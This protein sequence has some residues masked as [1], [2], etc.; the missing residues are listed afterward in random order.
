MDIPAWAFTAAMGLLGQGGAGLT[1]LSPIRL[2][3]ASGKLR[4]VPDSELAEP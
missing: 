2:L 4:Q 3:G 1:D